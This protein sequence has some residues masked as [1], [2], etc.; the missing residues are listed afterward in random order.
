MLIVWVSIGFPPANRFRLLGGGESFISEVM[1]V[2]IQGGV[3]KLFGISASGF[4]KGLAGSVKR[5]T[6][7]G[8]S[9]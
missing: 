5:E 8:P 9:Q 3:Q 7:V 4:D 2:P 6:R 1:V